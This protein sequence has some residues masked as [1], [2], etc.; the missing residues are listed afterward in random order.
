MHTW[1]PKYQFPNQQLG[2]VNDDFTDLDSDDEQF[3]ENALEEK[4]ELEAD[5]DSDVATWVDEISWK[6][7]NSSF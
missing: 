3:R 4:E 5:I 7:R 1:I 6:S 2:S